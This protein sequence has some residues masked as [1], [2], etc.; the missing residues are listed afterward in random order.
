MFFK[1]YFT[2][3]PQ[4]ISASI[5]T[6]WNVG[7]YQVSNKL[8]IYTFSLYIS[9]LKGFCYDHHYRSTHNM[10]T[11]TYVLGVLAIFPTTS[12]FSSTYVLGVLLHIIF[13]L[14]NQPN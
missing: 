11:L 2:P 9:N 14:L 6:N 7:I 12:N 10:S 3:L 8:K 1:N 5:T 4:R 13:T